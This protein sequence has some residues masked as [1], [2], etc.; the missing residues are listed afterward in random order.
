MNAVLTAAKVVT[1]R[2][3]RVSHLATDVSAECGSSAS[4]P[5]KPGSRADRLPVC[6][7]CTEAVEAAQAAAVEVEAPVVEAAP[8]VAKKAEP[9]AATGGDVTVRLNDRVAR[10]VTANQAPEH[11]A[12]LLTTA[13][14]TPCGRGLTVHVTAS[15]TH[16]EE[17]LTVL[18]TLTGA[19]DSGD[20]KTSGKGFRAE[21]VAKAAHHVRTG[22]AA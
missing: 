6:T 18:V 4:L 1:G 2:G 5:A 17:L 14:R 8:V 20:E 21:A 16:A 11:L 7:T 15:R 12:Q 22:L 13:P 3:A 10:W 9:Q 19:M